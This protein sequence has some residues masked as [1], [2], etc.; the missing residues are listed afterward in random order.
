MQIKET[1]QRL[2]DE[3]SKTEKAEKEAIAETKQGL[4]QITQ[5]K[6]EEAFA[7]KEKKVHEKIEEK[8][9]K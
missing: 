8:K 1:K 5:Q 4:K 3:S 9:V 7:E 2:V 6:K